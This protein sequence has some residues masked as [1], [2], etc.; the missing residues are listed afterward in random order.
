MVMTS[1]FQILSLYYVYLIDFFSE[2][3]YHNS[4]CQQIEYL[5]YFPLLLIHYHRIIVL[6]LKHNTNHFFSVQVLVHSYRHVLIQA[7]QCYFWR[8]S[9]LSKFV[10]L[11]F[12]EFNLKIIH[13]EISYLPSNKHFESCNILL[14]Q[15]IYWVL[16]N[17]DYNKAELGLFGLP[18]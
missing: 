2:Q 12:M 15:P 5:M 10:I 18:W 16:I 17:Q 4:I 7:R 9:F 13:E 1:Y 6:W 14:F 3:S 11:L 8:D